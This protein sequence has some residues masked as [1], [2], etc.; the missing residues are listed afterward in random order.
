M[1]NTGFTLFTPSVFSSINGWELSRLV[2][3]QSPKTP[4]IVITGFCDDKHRE[5]LNTNS[6]DAIIQKPFK[7]EEIE[8]TVQRLLNSGT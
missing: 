1:K 4:V 6:V 7:A 8:K 3:E 2:K 5:K